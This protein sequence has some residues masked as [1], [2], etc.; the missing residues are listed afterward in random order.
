MTPGVFSDEGRHFLERNVEFWPSTFTA[1]FYGTLHEVR[2]IPRFTKNDP[3][4]VLS[5]TRLIWNT[6]LT[7]LLCY[8]IL[9]AMDEGADPTIVRE[10]FSEQN[11]PLF[12]RFHDVSRNE[13]LMR[14][15][16]SVGVTLGLM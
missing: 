12:R 16:G 4:Y 13:L 11:I 10:Y 8:L 9:D 1:R 7:I 2:H 6:V 14:T 3:N 15:S 5:R